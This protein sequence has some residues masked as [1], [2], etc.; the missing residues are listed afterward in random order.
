MTA[1]L[2]STLLPGGLSEQVLHPPCVYLVIQVKAHPC[3][4]TA[5]ALPLQTISTSSGSMTVQQRSSSLVSQPSKPP[6]IHWEEE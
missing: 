2:I 1:C 6:L 4:H 3:C 5:D